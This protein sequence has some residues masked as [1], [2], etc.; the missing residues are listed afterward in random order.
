MTLGL[1]ISSSVVGFCLLNTAGEIVKSG[2]FDL[3]K[4]YSLT[5]KAEYFK[6]YIIEITDGFAISTFIIE[7][8]AK[9][10]AF[11]KTSTQ[12]IMT[13]AT[14]NGMCQYILHS[15]II[16]P[17]NQKVYKVHPSTARSKVVG[18]IPSPKISGIPQKEYVFQWFRKNIKELP[19]VK[20]SRDEADATII[21]KYGHMTYPSKDWVF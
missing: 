10:Y 11:G 7:D 6:T 2:Y 4:K 18:K 16:Y 1:D 12:T 17:K 9:S 20:K 8:F 21:A 19:D 3:P 15:L 5:E 13:L 14:F